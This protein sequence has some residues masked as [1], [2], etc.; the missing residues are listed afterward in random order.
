MQKK[1]LMLAIL[2]T[3]LSI[4]NSSEFTTDLDS[5][6]LEPKVLAAIDHLSRYHEWKALKAD[7][8]EIALECTDGLAEENPLKINFNKPWHTSDEAY[9]KA[10]FTHKN[11]E[12]Q[13]WQNILDDY[14]WIRRH[15]LCNAINSLN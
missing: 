14:F 3:G 5:Q 8:I 2:I 13:T 15:V 12:H 4:I 11:F 9:L 10:I 1:F 6:N 7:L